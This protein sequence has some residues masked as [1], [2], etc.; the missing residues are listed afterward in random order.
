MLKW[1][2]IVLGALALF[3]GI[4]VASAPA[5]LLETEV[6]KRVPGLELYGVDGSV[7]EGTLSQ[8]SHPRQ[9]FGSLS[10]SLSPTALVAGAIQAELRLDDPLFTGS[11][12]L[13]H[14]FSSGGLSL[15]NVQGKQEMF[16]VRE[17]LRGIGFYKPEGELLWQDVN[18]SLEGKRVTLASGLIEWQNASFDFFGELIELGEFDFTLEEDAGDLLIFIDNNGPLDIQGE[19]R[20]MLDRN[21][22]LKLD[23]SDEMPEKL[24]QAV[25][26]MVRPG[27]PGRLTVSLNGRY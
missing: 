10:W 27:E 2:F 3:A 24:R 13:E 5:S 15:S 4:L 22:I 26:Y 9:N 25:Q 8:L 23:L 16:A 14:P 12:E 17:Q 11:L 6:K 20:L 7:W 21:F 19:M 1:F 18:L